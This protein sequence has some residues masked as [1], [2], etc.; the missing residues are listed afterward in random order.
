MTE[1]PGTVDT[2]TSS[3]DVPYLATEVTFRELPSTQVLSAAM[4]PSI[5]KP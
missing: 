1:L 2:P 3:L 5:Q 4:V